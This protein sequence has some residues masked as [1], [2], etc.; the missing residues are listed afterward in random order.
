MP[1][2]EHAKLKEFEMMGNFITGLATPSR[3]AKTLEVWQAGM[4]PSAASPLH[5]HDA[6]EI[7]VV[8][9]GQGEAHAA[10]EV[11]R[12]RAPCTLILPGNQLH[13]LRN[14]GAERLEAIAVVPIGSKV[15]DA[16]GNEMV[17]PWR[18]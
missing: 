14:T 2:V 13:Q 6:E 7:V 11:A 10:G 1:V 3:G 4:A 9:T 17:L 15:F 12:F 5:R 8:L 18:E 16:D